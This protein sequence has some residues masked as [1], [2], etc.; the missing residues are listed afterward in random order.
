MKELGMLAFGV[1]MLVGWIYLDKHNRIP[2]RR[3]L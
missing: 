1:V 3:G 2:R